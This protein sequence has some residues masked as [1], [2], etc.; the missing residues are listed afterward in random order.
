MIQEEVM[1]S[2]YQASTVSEQIHI[3]NTILKLLTLCSFEEAVTTM[4]SRLPSLNEHINL[5]PPYSQE[6]IGVVIDK[7]KTY[8]AHLVQQVL[9]VPEE[10]Q[11]FIQLPNL[12][13]RGR[14]HTGIKLSKP[15]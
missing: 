14:E 8:I 10:D 12:F 13:V 9:F 15:G 3:G 2:S 7:L 1:H 4:E 6:S 11:D 5:N